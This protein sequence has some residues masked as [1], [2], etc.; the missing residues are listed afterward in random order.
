MHYQIDL[1]NK[2]IEI[3]C[4]YDRVW[5]QCCN[6]RSEGKKPDIIVNI[7]QDDINRERQMMNIG[8][9][10]YKKDPPD[11]ELESAALY[12]KICD[13]M[14]DFSTILMH[15]A[16]VS[17]GTQAYMFVA[18][19]GVGK[20]TRTKLFLKVVPGSFVVN[21]D[22]P[23]LIVKKEG[24]YACGT[25]WSGKECLNSNV[26]VPLHT[27]FLL[28]RGECTRLKRLSSLDALPELIQ[29]TYLPIDQEKRKK[30][31][32]VLMR[33]TNKVQCI[34]FVSEQTENSVREALKMATNT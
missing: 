11:L 14:V 6:Y 28:K 27:I 5:Y 24:V 9:N 16:V 4:K 21:G 32:Q 22:K 2:T 12:R 3:I 8:E 31:L 7:T 17:D 29:Q 1:A 26:I 33:L 34:S 10:G 23:L 25:P 13:E 19:S 18:R 30:A 20:T 15:G